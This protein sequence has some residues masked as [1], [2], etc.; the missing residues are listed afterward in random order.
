MEA[1]HDL[2]HW[3]VGVSELLVVMDYSCIIGD[4]LDTFCKKTH[5]FHRARVV[6]VFARLKSSVPKLNVLFLLFFVTFAALEW[7][8]PL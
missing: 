7:K 1:F 2:A 8:S 4:T 3:F 5:T 6:V